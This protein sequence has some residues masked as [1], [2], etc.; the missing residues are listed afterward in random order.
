MGNKM[1]KS[2]LTF[3][4]LGVVA[5]FISIY[6]EDDYI[7]GMGSIVIIFIGIGGY[8]YHPKGKQASEESNYR[9]VTSFFNCLNCTYCD[10]EHFDGLLADCKFFRMKIDKEH[11]CD[12]FKLSIE[13]LLK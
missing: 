9:L 7:W 1:K 13:K 11:V 8:L 10:M 3:I 6:L 12:L 4:V 2:Y 5:L